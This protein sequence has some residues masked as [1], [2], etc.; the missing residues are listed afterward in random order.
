M[1]TS[2]ILYDLGYSELK[3][4]AL[5]L[6][7]VRALDALLVDCRFKP[8][9]RDPR[10]RYNYLAKRLGPQYIH[11]PSLGNRNFRGGP[12]EIVDL[13][14]GLENIR[15]FLENS[16]VILMCGCW[17][18]EE[19]HRKLIVQVFSARYGIR[20]IPITRQIAVELAADR[21]MAFFQ[22]Q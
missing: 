20:S 8:S 1:N 22:E 18:R 2:T 17:N 15:K 5:L 21:Q 11:L 16:R 4:P 13:D 7:A 10:Y 14:A 12:I 9:S 19:C 6:D 3:S